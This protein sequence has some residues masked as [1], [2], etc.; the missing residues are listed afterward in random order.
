MLPQKAVL[1]V[2]GRRTEMSESLW[3]KEAEYALMYGVTVRTIRRWKAT[4][5]YDLDHPHQLHALVAC[6]QCQPKGF[7]FLA[8]DKWQ[9]RWLKLAEERGLLDD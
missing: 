7:D 3:F 4:G 6:Q 5:Y 1:F 9:N 8:G 2:Q